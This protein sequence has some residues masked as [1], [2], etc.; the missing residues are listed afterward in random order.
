MCMSDDNLMMK[1][2]VLIYY[3]RKLWQVSEIVMTRMTESRCTDGYK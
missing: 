1:V 2:S 3:L